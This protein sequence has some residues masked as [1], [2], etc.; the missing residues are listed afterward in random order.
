MMPAAT[1]INSETRKVWEEQAYNVV[2]A[3]FTDARPEF[4]E[5][6]AYTL[7]IAKFLN[8]D[9]M[10]VVNG[11]ITAYIIGLPEIE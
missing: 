11:V 8:M 4:I 2:S 1:V 9:S 10:T 6:M 7:M 5:A 3:A